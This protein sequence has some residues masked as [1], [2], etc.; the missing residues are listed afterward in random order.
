MCNR[1]MAMFLDRRRKVGPPKAVSFQFDN[2]IRRSQ[3]R[4]KRNYNTRKP[5]SSFNVATGQRVYDRDNVL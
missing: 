2:N 4:N 5:A 1:E 3:Q